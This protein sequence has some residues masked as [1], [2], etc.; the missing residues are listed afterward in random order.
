MRQTPSSQRMSLLPPPA[1]LERVTRALAVLDAIL[2]E[3][4]DLRI[5]SFQQ[6][7]DE[8]RGE[9]MASARDGSGDSW[10]IVFSEHGAF[11]KGFAHESRLAS[12]GARA[13]L[14]EGLPSVFAHSAVEPAFSMDDI[15]FALWNVGRGWHR[16][17]LE[18]PDGRDPDGSAELMRLLGGE[19]ADYV[20]FAGKYFERELSLTAVRAVY[21]GAPVTEA[22]LAALGSERTL[23]ELREDLDEV[24]WD[25]EIE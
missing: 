13:A 6:R 21:E 24:G 5:H 12:R 2:C 15:T 9:R 14:L 23:E 3:E 17:R 19:P 25:G 10:F 18:L 11:M 16:A 8:A 22:L 1:R 7:W 20:R 4:W